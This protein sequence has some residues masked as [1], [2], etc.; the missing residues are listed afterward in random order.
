MDA[1]TIAI[2]VILVGFFFGLFVLSIVLELL[3]K[4]K[5]D[6]EDHDSSS[7]KKA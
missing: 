3:K 1:G 2:V 5:I 6:L 7:K 4:P